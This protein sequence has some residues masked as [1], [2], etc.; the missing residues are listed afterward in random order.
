[1]A[2]AHLFYSNY[3]AEQMVAFIKQQLMYPGGDTNTEGGLE[4]ALNQILGQSGDREDVNNVVVVITDGVP[5]RPTDT[6]TARYWNVYFE[7]RGI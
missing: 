4:M 6:T 5:T 1:L 2:N 3:D 7:S